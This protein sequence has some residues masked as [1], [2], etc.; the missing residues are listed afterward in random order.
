[1]NVLDAKTINTQYGLE[2]YVDRVNHVKVTDL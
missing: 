1:M 2:I